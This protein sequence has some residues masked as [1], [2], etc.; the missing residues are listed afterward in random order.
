MA[1]IAREKGINCTDIALSIAKLAEA[2]HVRIPGMKYDLAPIENGVTSKGALTFQ[3]S[4]A[5]ESIRRFIYELEKSG[6]H[7]FIEQLHAER[8]NKTRDVAFMIQIGTFFKADPSPTPLNR[9]GT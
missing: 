4:G 6:P 2:N 3:A 7:L 9:R 1:I 5:Y 8:E